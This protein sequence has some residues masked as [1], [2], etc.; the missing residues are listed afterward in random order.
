MT[1]TNWNVG[2]SGDWSASANWSSGVPNTSTD[3]IINAF[4]SY[5][6]N[7]TA[8]AFASSLTIGGAGATLSE[9]VT[10]NLDIVH[11]LNVNAGKVILRAANTIGSVNLSGGLIQIANGMALGSGTLTMSGTSE[12]VGS[13]TET[14]ANTTTMSGN[15]TFAAVDGKVFTEDAVGWSFD[16]TSGGSITFGEG[17]NDGTILWKT[18]SGSITNPGHVAT[19]IAKGTLLCGDSQ[20]GFLFED[21]SQ[22][23]ID[24]GAT[25]DIGGFSGFVNNLLGGGTVTSSGAGATLGVIGGGAFSGKIINGVALE[26]AGGTLVLTDASTY[27]G[28]TTIDSSS[29]LQ[30]G[31]GGSTGSIV[32]DI[33]DNG[34][35]VYD[36]SDVLSPTA[37]ISG[38]GNVTYEGGGGAVINHTNIYDGI[39]TVIGE[40]VKTNNASAFGT[41]GTLVLQGA[42]MLATAGMTLATTH[43]TIT[44]NSTIAVAHGKVLTATAAGTSWALSA[45]VGAPATLNI[46]DG[47]NDGTVVWN[48]G[49]GSTVIDISN[50]F[51]EVHAGTFRGGDSSFDFLLENVGSVTVDAG[52]TLD[53]ASF[54]GTIVG[55]AGA[56]SVTAHGGAAIEIAG[57]QFG[58]VVSGVASMLIEDGV[59]FSGD[60]TYTQGTTIGTGSVLALG[61]GGTTGSVVGNITDNGGLIYDHSNN[62]TESDLIS[63][64]GTLSQFGS[65]VLTIDR[66]ESYSGGTFVTNGELSIDRSSAIGT[67]NL[68]LNG[69][70]FLTTTTVSLTNRLLMS[71]NVTIAAATGTQLKFGSASGWS[72]DATAPSSVTFGDGTHNG[73]ILFTTPA[74][75][76][77]TN[78]FHYAVDIHSGVLKA[79][80]S[81]LGFLLDDASGVSI[82][83]GATLNIA[84]FQNDVANLTGTGQLTNT[85]A[86]ITAFAIE[87]GNFGGTINGALLVQIDGEVA[88]TGSGNFTG[89]F[90]VES[91]SQLDL[92]GTWTQSLGFSTSSTAVLHNPGAFSGNIA[93]FQ[94]GDTLDVRGTDFNNAAFSESF[95]ATTGVLTVSDGTHTRHL[96]FTGGLGASNFAFASDG[97]GGTNVSWVSAMGAHPDSAYSPVLASEHPDHAV[98]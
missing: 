88:L 96:T 45:A 58:G 10:G 34:T 56:G 66:A 6:V 79:G 97:V 40:T 55:L 33:T 87:G 50:C 71:G 98:F 8:S 85:T 26:A 72:L 44:G 49:A 16:A 2:L 70:E 38:T 13:A 39:T 28:G 15:L 4:G 74:G 57:G 51:V 61:S 93:G 1:T 60:S 64:S 77:I 92:S 14:Y 29:T 22:T 36:H 24:A 83:T 12:L 80:D 59:V 17:A 7:V 90:L 54:G 95:N 21:A 31:N 78:T 86:T 30:L 48:T 9:S 5:S 62:L 41:G 46:G 37:V 25:L 76:G 84:G 65:G 94:S 18:E 27:T 52:A 42:E 81:S 43:L 91:G 20:W 23:K 69:G 47:A 82:D 3:V 35:L 75:S 68:N 89:G 63:G 67:G 53:L 11:A 19:E 32:G 73:T